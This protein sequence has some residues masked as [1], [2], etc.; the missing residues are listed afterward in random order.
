MLKNILFHTFEKVEKVTLDM[1]RKYMKKVKT[2][3]KV[4]EK[5]GNVENVAP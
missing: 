4:D 2:I 5:F 1:C 3:G